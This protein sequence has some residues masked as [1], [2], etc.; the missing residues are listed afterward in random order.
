MGTAD[1]MQPNH[2]IMWNHHIGV[3]FIV[4]AYVDSSGNCPCWLFSQIHVQK[5]IP[6][7]QK[8]EQ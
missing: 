8:K 4:C 7:I 5:S 3:M 1:S 6:S 2:C